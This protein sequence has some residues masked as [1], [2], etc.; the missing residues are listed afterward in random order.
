MKRK[1]VARK[2]C[3]KKKGRSLKI[4]TITTILNLETKN[5]DVYVFEGA[6]LRIAWNSPEAEPAYKGSYAY[7]N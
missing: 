7:T 3:E 2:V 5:A 1:E 6:H 4:R